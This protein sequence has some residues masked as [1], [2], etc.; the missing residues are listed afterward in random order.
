MPWLGRRYGLLCI[1]LFV[2]CLIRMRHGIGSW[3]ALCVPNILSALAMRQLFIAMYGKFSVSAGWWGGL[4]VFKPRAILPAVLGV[5]FDR[6]AG[7]LTFAPLYAFAAAG[8]WLCLRRDW[9]RVAVLLVPFCVQLG[10][11]SLDIQEWQGGYSPPPRYIVCITPIPAVLAAI[12][13]ATA[14]R[15]TVGRVVWHVGL[16][17]TALVT[18]VLVANSRLQ[19]HTHDGVNNLFKKFVDINFLFPTF[20]EGMTTIG[21][22]ARAVVFLAAIAALTWHLATRARASEVCSTEKTA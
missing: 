1:C 12:G 6:E 14:V 2:L 21:S 3:L 18:L 16:V 8:V 20:N 17:Y 9:R 5:L 4:F 15:A 10:F 13:C 11:V 19:Y 22:Y 7:L